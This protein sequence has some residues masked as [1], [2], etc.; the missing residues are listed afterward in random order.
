MY[1]TNIYDEDM[2][3]TSFKKVL[4]DLQAAGAA[5]GAAELVSFHRCL[6]PHAL[7]STGAPTHSPRLARSPRLLASL[8][9]LARSPHTSGVREEN[10]RGP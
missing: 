4:M 3:F 2:E 6:C 1:Q 5:G 8:A 9:R 10:V 7:T